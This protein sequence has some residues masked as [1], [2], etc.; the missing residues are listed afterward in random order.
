MNKLE[1][2]SG[3]L[4]ISNNGIVILVIPKD[5]CAIN[6]LSLIETIPFISIFNKY[7][8][9]STVV[10]SQPLA[11]CEDSSSTPFTVNSFTAFAEVNLGF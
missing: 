1:I 6:T 11:N 8:G 2:V 9:T 3:S 5:V 10:F 7:L 4:Q